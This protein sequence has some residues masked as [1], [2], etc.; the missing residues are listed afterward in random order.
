VVRLLADGVDPR[1][2]TLREGADAAG[3]AADLVDRVR[4]EVVKARRGRQAIV[5]HDLGC[6]TGSM[7]RWLAPHCPA[8]NGGFCTTGTR[9][10][11]R[12]PPGT[13]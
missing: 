11:W 7:L 2:L 8:R 4:A 1:W 5:V 9:R 12:T 3:R 10:C 13:G 6:G